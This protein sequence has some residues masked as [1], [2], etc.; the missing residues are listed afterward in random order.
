MVPTPKRVTRGSTE[1]WLVDNE[2]EVL[3]GRQLPSNREVLECF[4]YQTRNLKKT[5]KQSILSVLRMCREFYEAT[6]IPV[7]DES[8]A[9][10]R[11]EKLLGKYRLLLKNKKRINSESQADRESIFLVELNDLFDI[12]HKANAKSLCD[13]ETMQFL[14]AQRLPGREGRLD[15]EIC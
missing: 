7:I 3:R 9:I 5:D 13:Q 14:E 4:Y 6:N 2:K 1:I 15:C 10:K 11:F 12:S 8:H